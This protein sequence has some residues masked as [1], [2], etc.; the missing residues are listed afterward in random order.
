MRLPLP[1][2]AAP[3][4]GQSPLSFLLSFFFSNLITLRCYQR[5]GL[6]SNPPHG[7]PDNGSIWL[8]MPVKGSIRPLV[9][10]SLDKTAEPSSRFDCTTEC[11]L[12]RGREGGRE[13]GL[14]DSAL[15]R[16]YQCQEEQGPGGSLARLAYHFHGDHR[17]RERERERKMGKQLGLGTSCAECEGG[18]E[19]SC[20]FQ[21]G[22]NGWVGSCL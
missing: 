11:N 2:P 5:E 20:C 16:I 7:S 13:E 12:G 22:N 3:S 4:A 9:Q 10:F 1:S 18:A 21:R 15:S 8:N 6:Q 19:G 17:G 14:S